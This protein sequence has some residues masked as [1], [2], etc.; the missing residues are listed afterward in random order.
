MRIVPHQFYT[1]AYKRLLII[2]LH[3][4]TSFSL[5]TQLGGKKVSLRPTDLL[6]FYSAHFVFLAI[7]IYYK[8]RLGFYGIETIENLVN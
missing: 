3:N 2:L 6:Y 4:A 8:M 1:F 7:Q 5:N